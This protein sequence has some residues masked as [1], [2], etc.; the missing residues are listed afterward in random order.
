MVAADVVRDLGGVLV[1]GVG[2]SLAL[3]GVRGAVEDRGGPGVRGDAPKGAFIAPSWRGWDLRAGVG[4]AAGFVEL[5][6]WVNADCVRGGL[7][8]PPKILPVPRK[9]LGLGFRGPA[10]RTLE[11]LVGAPAVDVV[12]LAS[13]EPL[14]ECA[15]ETLEIRTA[16]SP[17]R[18]SWH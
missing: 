6:A 11:P 2:R 17:N 8:V 16:Q 10:G 12:A 7:D 18:Q 5:G 1:E 9:G 4:L 13:K 15:E 3:A 14:L